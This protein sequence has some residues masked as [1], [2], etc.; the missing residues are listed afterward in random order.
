MLSKLSRIRIR[1]HSL[2]LLLLYMKF[3]RCSDVCYKL[4]MTRVKVDYQFIISEL[5]LNFDYQ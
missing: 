3:G 5:I 4:C 1:D 2:L